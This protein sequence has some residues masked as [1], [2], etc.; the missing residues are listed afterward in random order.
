MHIPN[1]TPNIGRKNHV[2]RLATWL[3]GHS[4]LSTVVQEP[5]QRTGVVI[6]HRNRKNWNKC[7]I[8]WSHNLNFRVVLTIGRHENAIYFFFK[9]FSS[10]SPPHFFQTSSKPFGNISAPFRLVKP[11]WV[12]DSSHIRKSFFPKNWFWNI[13]GN[14]LDYLL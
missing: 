14:T 3:S 6:R 12:R 1:I 2:R 11:V 4:S 13:S 5:G 7:W 10:C 9:L 8:T